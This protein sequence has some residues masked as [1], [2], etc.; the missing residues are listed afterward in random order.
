[1]EA[2]RSW[3]DDS[4]ELIDCRITNVMRRVPLRQADSLAIFFGS[5]HLGFYANAGFVYPN[6][7][8]SV[9]SAARDALQCPALP[10][11]R[12]PVFFLLFTGRLVPSTMSPTSPGV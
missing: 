2:M 3:C 5:D 9:F 8:A 10:G 11:D 12:A 4:P 7:V 6:L 1:M